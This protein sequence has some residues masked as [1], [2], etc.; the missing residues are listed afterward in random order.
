M[1]KHKIAGFALTGALLLQGCTPPVACRMSATPEEEKAALAV[2]YAANVNWRGASY[3]DQ[4]NSDMEITA[5]QTCGTVVRLRFDPKV[6]YA[7]GKV[8]YVLTAPIEET[9]VNISTGEIVD[10]HVDGTVLADGTPDELT[11]ERQTPRP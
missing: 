1:M 6:V 9:A 11:L 5:R 7:G 3:A 10:H 4:F 2:I 8:V